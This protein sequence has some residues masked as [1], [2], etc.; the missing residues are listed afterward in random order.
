MYREKEIHAIPGIPML[1]V[2]LMTLVGA[3]FMMVFFIHLHFVPGVLGSLLGIIL[4]ILLLGGLTVVNPGEG[5]VV[6]LFGNYAGTLRQQ[7]FQWVNPF[8]TR[9][10]VSMRV[11]I[12]RAPN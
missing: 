10:K 5:V 7:G 11:R 9:R 8:T 4:A 1:L 2:L 6:Q 3:I 12:S